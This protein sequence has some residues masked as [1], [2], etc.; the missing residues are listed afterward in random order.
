MT[1]SHSCCSNTFSDAG[2][3]CQ[4]LAGLAEISLTS[5]LHVLAMPVTCFSLPLGV[6]EGGRNVLKCSQSCLFSVKPLLHA[7]NPAPT[8]QRK[9]R[10][11]AAA[12][13]SKQHSGAAL[14]LWLIDLYAGACLH[15]QAS[16]LE[17]LL[18]FPT[19]QR[20]AD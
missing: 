15:M 14:T 8:F 1:C 10:C 6:E 17:G 13:P 12:L 3:Y 16:L 19:D 2:M 9:L 20:F 18:F 4:F 5:C 11:F 7:P